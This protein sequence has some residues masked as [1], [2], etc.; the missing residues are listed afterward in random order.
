MPR[1]ST[2]QVTQVREANDIVDVIG[3]YLELKP[4]GP[5]HKALC[6]FHMEKTPSF[7]VSRDRQMY[8]CF[9]CGKGGDVIGFVMEYEGLAFA[10]TVEKLADRMGI[11]LEPLEG[12]FGQKEGNSS[13]RAAG[14]EFLAFAQRFYS[15]MLADP[16]I[17]APGREYL[18]TRGLQ[19]ST[20]ARF[21]L[22]LAPN[23]WNHLLDAAKRER[24]APAVLE[25]SGLFKEGNHGGYDAFRNRLIIPI[26]DVMGKTVAFG[27]RDLSG[28]D[29]AKYINS[30]ETLIY[31]KSR[32]LYGLRDAREAMRRE[33]HVLLVEGYF[34]VLRCF[35]AGIEN[36]V[37][38]CGTA[39]TEEQAKLIR[40]YVPEVV[41]L[42]DGDAAGLKA[43]VEA[44]GIL[45]R[46]GLE[47][48]ATAL[49]DGQD[50]DDFVRAHGPE[51]LRD[52]VAKAPDF[53]EFII[54]QRAPKS[55]EEKNAV[56]K[57]LFEVM[58]AF[59]EE[60]R[61]DEYL[62]R[63]AKLLGLHEWTCRREFTKFLRDRASRPVRLV[64]EAPQESL[65]PLVSEDV[66]CVAAVLAEPALLALVRKT[67]R[68]GTLPEGPLTEVLLALEN[69][70]DDH[71]VLAGELGHEARRLYAAAANA[72][73]QTGEEGARRVVSRLASLEHEALR[74]DARRVQQEI[75]QA[76]RAGDTVRMLTLIQEKAVIERSL[77]VRSKAV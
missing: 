77:R 14:L 9:G 3:A 67:Y 66:Q 34:D 75:E 43:A 27:G 25:A 39:L 51:A 50:P 18:A 76:E 49:P 8:H 41:V 64:E 1:F 23:G 5:R 46:A 71:S 44:L 13:L 70:D 4:A 63:A 31:K 37:A 6:P 28:E 72:E 2:E 24:V 11:R 45:A 35:D 7:T 55:V 57:R 20:M 22:G 47:V 30:P 19:D 16:E 52:A 26:H 10:E 69:Q 40:R 12:S 36:V 53:V 59:D 61:R 38:T 15:S 68:N 65:A 74:E 33:K 32:T 58:A 62:K 60:I 42:Y 48:R 73:A 54:A 17:G 56:A 21:N 29:V